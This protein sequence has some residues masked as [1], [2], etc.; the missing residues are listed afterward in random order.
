MRVSH[1]V[2]SCTMHSHPINGRTG[3]KARSALWPRASTAHILTE[4]ARQKGP[5]VRQHTLRH[6]LIVD[7]GE[8]ILH[9]VVSPEISAE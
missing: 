7:G 6:P 1:A 9:I 8:C 5:A 2:H 4:T 3:G